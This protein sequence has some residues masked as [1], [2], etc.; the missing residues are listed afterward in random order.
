MPEVRLNAADAAELAEMLQFLNQWLACDP[1][2]LGASLTQIGGHP[3]L[4]PGRT[5]RRPGAVHLPARRQRRRADLRPL[6]RPPGTGRAH[7]KWKPHAP[8]IT[9]PLE[10][11]DGRSRHDRIKFDVAG[12]LLVGGYWFRLRCRRGGSSR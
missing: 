5:A 11:F 6:T 10:G 9:S 3:G 7:P 8:R 2:R 1:A 4:R 12:H